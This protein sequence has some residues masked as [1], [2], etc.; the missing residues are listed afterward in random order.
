[1][2]F[3]GS[4]PHVLVG[5]SSKRGPVMWEGPLPMSGVPCVWSRLRLVKCGGFGKQKPSLRRSRERT[6]DM[7]GGALSR[8]YRGL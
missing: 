2:L 1:M 6:G 3:M 7:Q 5:L 4:V 8:G